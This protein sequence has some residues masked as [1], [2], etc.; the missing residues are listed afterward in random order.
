[1]RLELG[2]EYELSREEMDG[3]RSRAEVG[4]GVG[5]AEGPKNSSFKERLGTTRWSMRGVSWGI[6]GVSSGCTPCP[7]SE[8]VEA[9]ELSDVM[10]PMDAFDLREVPLRT[11][12]G[13]IGVG[14]P[15]QGEP[16]NAWVLLPIDAIDGEGDGSGDGAEAGE[17]IDEAEESRLR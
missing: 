12:G 1:M 16:K 6:R 11:L 3:V 14:D 17:E 9:E 10:E 8:E 7:L 4:C 2:G 5:R 13:G 15:S